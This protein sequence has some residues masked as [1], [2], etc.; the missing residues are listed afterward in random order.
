MR[1]GGLA[2]DR[3]F[4][5][6]LE[7][8]VPDLSERVVADFDGYRDPGNPADRDDDS[9]ADGDPRVGGG[10]EPPTQHEDEHHRYEHEGADQ[11]VDDRFENLLK[12]F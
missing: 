9:G 10:N 11:C 3:N 6:P 2:A 4:E 1:G 7:V 5:L 8:R 12:H